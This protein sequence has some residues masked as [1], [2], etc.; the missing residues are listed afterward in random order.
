MAETTHRHL[1]GHIINRLQSRGLSPEGALR[2]TEGHLP[3][4]ENDLARLG[5]E[6]GRPGE[7]NFL[8]FRHPGGLNFFDFN[9]DGSF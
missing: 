7:L 2:L 3:T 8:N 9:R 1:Q 6:I 4:G 5:S